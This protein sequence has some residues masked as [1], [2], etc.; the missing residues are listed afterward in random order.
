MPSVLD[1]G[2]Q[3]RAIEA[4]VLDFDGTIA[5]TRIDFAEMRRRVTSLFERC[6]LWRP[7]VMQGRYVLE[8][9]EIAATI[10]RRAGAPEHHIRQA[11]EEEI[12]DIE[13]RHAQQATLCHGA[14][15]ALATLRR[16]GIRTGIITRNC[17]QAVTHVLARCGLA[18]DILIPR[19]AAPRVKP[20]PEHLLQALRGL[21]VPPRAAAM[22]GDHITDM[23]CARGVGALAV[24]VVG[25]SSTAD[26]LR[27]AGAHYVAGDLI[28]A[29]AYLAAR[30]PLGGC[31]PA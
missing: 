12:R 26:E 29:A 15:A 23:H 7:E 19:D 4:V 25:A 31:R 30:A 11:A 20:D 2:H 17:R 5:D 9:V 13:L 28:E 16:A 24:A 6:G 27:R 8:M 10:A 3:H 18:A 21:C 1:R 22:V 14:A